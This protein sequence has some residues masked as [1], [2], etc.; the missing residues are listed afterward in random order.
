M[1]TKLIRELDKQFS[2]FIRRRDSTNGW[3]ACITCGSMY[4]WQKMDCGHYIKRQYKATRWDE[5]NCNAQ[6]RKCNWLE[7]GANEKYKIAINKKYGPGTNDILEM[8]KHN[9]IYLPR[10]RYEYEIAKYEKLNKESESGY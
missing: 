5:K 9:K 6:C 7:Q 10:W 4:P 3:C 8:R 1:I 2:I